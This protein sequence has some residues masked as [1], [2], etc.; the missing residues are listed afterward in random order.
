MGEQR[1]VDTHTNDGDAVMKE[2]DVHPE[3]PNVVR[4]PWKDAAVLLGET[5][6][7]H[8][9]K[10]CPIDL[11]ADKDDDSLCQEHPCGSQFVWY[12]EHIAAVNKV[13]NK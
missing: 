3:D 5:H 6:L 1:N 8:C 10:G 4:M 11:I 9:C 13:R 7:Q 2:G 12:G